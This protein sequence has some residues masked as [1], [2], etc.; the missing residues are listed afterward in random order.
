[1][2]SLFLHFTIKLVLL[3]LTL[4]Y[5]IWPSQSSADLYESEENVIATEEAEAVAITPESRPD[6]EPIF[7]E[8]D[9]IP[10]NLIRLGRGEFYSPYAFIADKSQRTLSLWRQGSGLP[11]FVTAFPMDMGSN[12]GDKQVLGD[13]KTPEGIYFFETMYEGRNLNYEEY[14]V[15][16]FPMDY[17]NFFDRRDGKTGSGIWLHAVPD[18]T[19]LWR[20]SR[21]C[22]VVRNEIIRDITQYINIGQTPIIVEESVSY[23]HAKQGAESQKSWLK[24]LESW[25]ASWQDKDLDQYMNF[26]AESFRSNNMNKT[27]WRQH[28]DSLNKRYE[29]INVRVI[30]PMIYTQNNRGIIR[31]LQ[32]YESDHNSDFG[33]KYLFVE[34]SDDGKFRI[35]NE[36]WSPL[37][38]EV[39][40][41]LDNGSGRS[42]TERSP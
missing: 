15:R 24:W 38:L 34:K 29:Y 18:T 7:P 39:L 27:A 25:R 28:K 1:M 19:S 13:K 12:L 33:E 10:A 20:G 42:A 40:A 14:G 6:P 3:C 23:V 5:F 22:L 26:Y 32:A 21:G 11:Q 37:G 41:K 9:T 31:F 4:G 2:T 30:E 17:P 16:A 36:T 8:P 35:L